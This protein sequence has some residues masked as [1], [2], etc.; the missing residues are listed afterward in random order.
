V[1]AASRPSRIACVVTFFHGFALNP[2]PFLAQEE[3]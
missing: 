3:T 2:V 1:A